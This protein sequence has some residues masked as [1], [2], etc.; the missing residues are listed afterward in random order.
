MHKDLIKLTR[1]IFIH[2]YAKK[3]L[4]CKTRG[5]RNFIGL[6]VWLG[7]VA[8]LLLFSAARENP[9]LAKRT[10][11]VALP[12]LRR[13]LMQQVS[14]GHCS[15]LCLNTDENSKPVCIWFLW[16]VPKPVPCCPAF[17]SL[18]GWDFSVV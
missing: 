9:C 1:N 18:L 12:I 16:Y 2:A 3:C 8:I 7:Y 15:L 14:S 10:Y 4:A 17:K 11:C 5:L 6:G 13:I